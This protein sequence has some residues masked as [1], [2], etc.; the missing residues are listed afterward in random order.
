MKYIHEHPDWPR[1]T[2]RDDVLAA[3]LADVRHRQ[4]RLIGRMESLGFPL[5]EESVLSTLTEEIVKSG[6]IEGESLDAQQVRSSVARRLGIEFA[7]AVE[8][9]RIV[10]GVVDLMIDA[11]ARYDEALTEERLFAWHAA[12]FPTGRSGINRINVGGCRLDEDGPMEV[13]SGPM[14]RE[15]VHFVAPAATR[16]TREISR[17]LEWFESTGDVDPVINAGIAHL[18]FVTIHPFD[19]G[20][21][22]IARAVTEMSLARSE[23]SRQR[24]YS[25][26]SAIRA[27]RKSYYEILEQTQ[28]SGLDVTEWLR[29][30]L[31]TL[32][33]AF[34]S[35]DSTLAAVMAKA[36]FWD[37][38]RETP[39]SARQRLV[40][41]RLLDGFHGNLTSGKWAKL[42]KTSQDTAARDI[43]DLVRKGILA[44]GPAGGRS[45]H[46]DLVKVRS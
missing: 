8:S 34:Q 16:L 10:D 24:F 33:D 42:T 13:V 26:S 3:L 5:R 18:W 44:R 7:G 11:T 39:I 15:R 29:W 14:G 27:R 36:D 43:D 37:V 22:R 41:N 40:I 2:W 19:D 35:N 31:E 46:Y 28:K 17:F 23:K 38:H 32:R 4:G 25:M 6:E 20:N 21:G 9:D 30:F 12:L 1:F 45:T